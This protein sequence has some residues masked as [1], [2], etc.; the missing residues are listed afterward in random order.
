MRWVAKRPVA[1]LAAVGVLALAGAALALRLE[2]SASTDTLVD[3]GSPA[4]EATEDFRQE[5]GEEPVV[6]LVKGELQQS[7]LTPDLGTLLRLEGCLS[8]NV[9]EEGL[10][11]LPE[12]VH[13]VRARSSR[14]RSSTGPARSST[15]PPARSPRASRRSRR[16]RRRRRRRRPRPRAGSSKRRGDPPAEQE[17]LAEQ[18]RSLVYR[19][20]H[21]GD[22]AARPPLRPDERPVA[23]QHRLRLAARV[24]P[25]PRRRPAEGAVR[26]P[27]PVG[28]R[29][30]D[31]DP[32]EADAVGVGARG[33]GRPD[34]GGRRPR[35]VRA[36][37]RR[38][39][40]S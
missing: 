23:R 5:F 25:E 11:T 28:Q 12:V 27:L 10:R 19:P 31:P 35:A 24:R 17:R 36:R 15:R 37:A 7:I 6:I 20:V 3:K 2:P 26:L 18:A 40:T 14:R 22:A 32:D 29:R 38:P 13:L 8:G 33:G 30:A 9:P 39:S 1:V 16:R 4:F 34:P 21:R